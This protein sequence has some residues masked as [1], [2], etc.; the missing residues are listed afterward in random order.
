MEIKKALG[1]QSG[2][3]RLSWRQHKLHF[4]G[5]MSYRVRSELLSL[6]DDRSYRRALHHLY[7][8]SHRFTGE[9]I[10]G[11]IAGHAWETLESEA[12]GCETMWNDV[13]QDELQVTD[14]VNEQAT[15]HSPKSHEIRRMT[16]ISG[17]SPITNYHVGDRARGRVSGAKEFGA[18]VEL[19]PG[20]SGLVHRSKMW[21]YV[22]DAREVIHPGEEI[23]V[24]IL[25]VN[26]ERGNLE[27]S[28]QIPEHDPLLYYHIGDK[29]VG[30]VTEVKEFGAFVELEPGA[31]GLVHRSKMWGYVADARDVVNL[32]DEVTGLILTADSGKAAARTEHA[33]T[34]V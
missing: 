13:E 5:R 9:V 3:E 6:T 23:E 33:D 34:G 22:A 31:S 18:F 28:M 7:S 4:N 26:V 25:N 14:L 21:G 30:R 10:D 29:A 15:D 16:L 12:H 20:A 2:F 1:V 11:T 17:A 27:L 24:L 19:E 32:N 8:L